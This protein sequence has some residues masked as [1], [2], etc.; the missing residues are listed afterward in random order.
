MATGKM[1]A[2]TNPAMG[3]SAASWLHIGAH[4]TLGIA[5]GA[6]VFWPGCCLIL[7]IT[8]ALARRRARAASA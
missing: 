7:W 1:N 6:L 5:S 2:F 8:R 4:L 3:E